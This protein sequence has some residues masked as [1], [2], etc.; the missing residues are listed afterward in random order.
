LF[1]DSGTRCIVE[2]IIAVSSS[3]RCVARSRQA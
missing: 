1:S 3:A 2:R